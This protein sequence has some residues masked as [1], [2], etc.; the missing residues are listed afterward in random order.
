MQ[1]SEE[2]KRTQTC[3]LLGQTSGQDS[4]INVGHASRTLERG[5]EG[6]N[7]ASKH[8]GMASITDCWLSSG[9]QHGF[10]SH[11]SIISAC[12]GNQDWFLPCA[13][14]LSDNTAGLATFRAHTPKSFTV[15]CPSTALCRSRTKEQ[16]ADKQ[17][18]SVGCMWTPE[19]GKRASIAGNCCSLSYL[20]FP[21]LQK[22]ALIKSL[23]GENSVFSKL[24]SPGKQTTLKGRLHTQQ[25]A[26]NRKELSGIFGA[27]RCSYLTMLC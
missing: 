4:G 25:Q 20:Q 6:T 9:L 21:H 19:R 18:E 3:T 12:M 16:V 24:V 8:K 5:V 15:W 14:G 26:A 23:A 11:S 27:G 17:R 7:T 13:H 2:A 1:S 22:V 10:H